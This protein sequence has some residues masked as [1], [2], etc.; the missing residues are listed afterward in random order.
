VRRRSRARTTSPGA[1]IATTAPSH[2]TPRA[3]A[4]SP[5]SPAERATWKGLIAPAALLALAALLF[6]AA[7]GSSLGPGLTPSRF[8]ALAAVLYVAGVMSGLCGFGFAAPGALSLFLLP[9]LTAIPLLQGL[10]TFNQA[11]SIAQLRREMPWRWKE[12]FPHGPGPLVLGGLATAPA[13]IWVLNHLPARTLT[14]L[15]GVATLCYA[16][17]ALVRRHEPVGPPGLPAAVGVG[18]LG[19]IVGGFTA[20]SGLV[21]I[22]WC[23]L[24]GLSRSATRALVQPYTIVVQ[25]A[26]VAWHAMR[27]PEHFG[28]SFWALLALTVPVVLPGTLT[29][30]W[31][32]RRVSDHGFRRASL[33]LLALGALALILRAL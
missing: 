16:A 5:A 28:P 17:F 4:A 10:S 9:P 14:I 8:A 21:V 7:G 18:A 26:F 1:T 20:Q 31:L 30:V 25:T 23:G 32:Y 29:G 3:L 27:N 2:A 13:G 6:A 24:R 11:L 15:V 33:A 22:V 12:W 19:G